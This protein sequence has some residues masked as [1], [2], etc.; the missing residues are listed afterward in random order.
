MITAIYGE[1]GAGKTTLL[2]MVA[3]LANPEKGTILVNGNVWFSSEKKINLKTQK[4]KVGFV[5]QDYALFDNM[6]VKQNIQFA[7]KDKKNVSLVNRLLEETQL[8][9][10]SNEFPSHI[11]GGQKQRV[12]LARA[13]AQ[14][15]DVL[16]M[17]EPLSALDIE[18][19]IKL[20]ELILEL[21]DAYKMTTIFVSHDIPEIFSLANKVIKIKNGQITEYNS[22]KAAFDRAI[23]M[24]QYNA[25]FSF[26]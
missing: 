19:R 2:R 5:F 8:S 11:S 15:P 26:S 18:T 22:P 20:R 23:L 24:K 25:L 1:S 12:A 16:L 7:L 17:D 10:L 3:G 4:R 6:T 14:Q 13:L 21:H 9:K